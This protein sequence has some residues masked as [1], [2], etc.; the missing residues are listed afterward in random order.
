MSDF[1]ANKLY[2]YCRHLSAAD[3]FDDLYDKMVAAS[4]EIV[5]QTHWDKIKF[6]KEPPYYNIYDPYGFSGKI[7]FLYQPL[8][9]TTVQKT[10]LEKITAQQQA[11]RGSFST[12]L[13]SV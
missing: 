9:P 11:L 10:F 6:T 4:H 5:D 7:S 8:F 3:E 2:F 13:V 1:D 12:I